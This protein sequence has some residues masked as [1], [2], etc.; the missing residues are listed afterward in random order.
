VAIGNLENLGTKNSTQWQST[1]VPLASR[2]CRRC[3]ALLL[4]VGELNAPRRC[5]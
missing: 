5:H 4:G 2:I 1:G 3:F